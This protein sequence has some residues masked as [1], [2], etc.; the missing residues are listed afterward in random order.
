MPGLTVDSHDASSVRSS[1]ASDEPSRPRLKGSGLG[2]DIHSEKRSRRHVPTATPWGAYRR[3]AETLWQRVAEGA[4]NS[5]SLMPSETALCAEFGVSRNTIRRA[6]ATL[7]ADGL[8]TVLPGVGRVVRDRSSSS[9]RVGRQALYR[10]IAD[11]V[12]ADIE[13]GTLPVGGAVPGELT[14]AARHG[15]SRWTAHRALVVLLDAG[16][17]ETVPGKGRVV[18]RRP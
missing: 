12:R 4:Y 10:C 2:R 17:V 14:L 16:L 1:S 9:A 5:G 18:R 8:V 7:E 3:I 6:L 13:D 15:V 11:R